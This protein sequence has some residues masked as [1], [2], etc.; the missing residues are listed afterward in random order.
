M[1]RPLRAKLS[2][3]LLLSAGLGCEG[4]PPPK[5]ESAPAAAAPAPP[6]APA[7][8][9]PE[10]EKQLAEPEKPAE[11]KAVVCT[12]GSK[13]TFT[14]P[15]LEKEV[16]RKAGKVEGELTL[17]DVRKV[18]SVDLTRA[19]VELESLDPCAL[20][21]L[22]GLHHLYVGR[23]S[24]TD[25]TPIKGLTKL[26]GLRLSMNPVSDISALAGMLQMDRLDLG[27]TQVRDLSP[28]KKMS[29]L[30]EL[31]LDD[32]PVEDLSP[33]AG[34]TSLERLSIK[35]TRVSDL[36]PL[37]SLRK[38]KFLYVGGSPVESAGGLARPG[39]KISAED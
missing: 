36:S 20:P 35:R 37:K 19:G 17:A 3:L 23:G 31:M 27:R 7:A 5:A 1:P 33:L 28:L 34:A 26:E 9:A 15:A 32:T 16:R 22:T 39:L 10:P 12:P 6:A 38:L 25:L 8:P 21:L 4:S 30:T 2:T 24:I 13:P 14:D 18:R 11:K 29:K